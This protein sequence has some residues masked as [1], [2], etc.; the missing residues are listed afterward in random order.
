[1]CKIFDKIEEC[2][3]IRKMLYYDESDYP[4]NE[5]VSKISELLYNGVHLYLN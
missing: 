1:M 4:E 3:P 5:E 2:S